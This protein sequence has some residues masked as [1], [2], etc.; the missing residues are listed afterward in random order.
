MAFPSIPALAVGPRGSHLPTWLARVP[1]VHLATRR[2]SPPSIPPLPLPLEF[3]G[4]ILGSNIRI[5]GPDFLSS[6]PLVGSST[7]PPRSAT[8]LSDA[9]FESGTSDGNGEGREDD[10]DFDTFDLSR[11]LSA[12]Q[13]MKE[14][15]SGI[16][17]E[18]ERRKAA[19]RVALGLVYGLQQEDARVEE[20]A[21]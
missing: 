19:A 21:Q 17:D 16:T 14:E 10:F 3:P 12:L 11:V 8:L 7:H 9:S 18:S 1:R 5:F 2:G 15:I 13:G 20:D 4:P 6:P